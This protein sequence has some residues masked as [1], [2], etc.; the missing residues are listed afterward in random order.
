M[1]FG[2]KPQNTDELNEL[3]GFLFVHAMHELKYI[4]YTNNHLIFQTTEIL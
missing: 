3:S 4:G 2:G 1:F